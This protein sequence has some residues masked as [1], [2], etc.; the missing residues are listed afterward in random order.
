MKNTQP[1]KFAGLSLQHLDLCYRV[2]LTY[3]HDFSLAEDLVQ[4]TY[5]K[6]LEKFST[7]RPGTNFKAWLLRILHNT[8]ID[9]LRHRR[10]VGPVTY[11]EEDCLSEKSS[12]EPTAW[13]DAED[14]LEN[15]SDEQMIRA[16]RELPEEQRLALYLVDV[17]QFDHQEAAEILSVAVGTIKS[18]TSRAR[19]ILRKSLE[20]HARDLGF[21]ER[22]A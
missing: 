15:F 3:C 21:A 4:T 22:Y 13:S 8:W 18:R 11:I 17:E 5:V 2:A 12:P 9:E 10:V 6:G 19:R 14:L 16:L 7:Y 20:A 1:D